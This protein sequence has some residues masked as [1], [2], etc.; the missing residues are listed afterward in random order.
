M[1]TNRT[2]KVVESD[3]KIHHVLLQGLLLAAHTDDDCANPD[4]ACPNSGKSPGLG[5]ELPVACAAGGAS[6]QT[7]FAAPHVGEEGLPP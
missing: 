3:M 1:H 7:E 4:P 2:Q 5:S 6:L